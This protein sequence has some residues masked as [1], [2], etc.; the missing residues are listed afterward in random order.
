MTNQ[1]VINSP[2]GMV[3]IGGG[4]SGITSA[5]EASEVGYDV[6]LIEKNPYLGGR[7]TRAHQY[8]PKLCSPS[9]GLEI[10]FRCIKTNP[11]I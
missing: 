5:V 4:I 6:F 8:F 9:C 2:Q 3:V 11:R 1:E 7:V 10:N